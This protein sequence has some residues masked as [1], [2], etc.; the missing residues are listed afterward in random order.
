MDETDENKSDG[1]IKPDTNN[2]ENEP[3]KDDSPDLLDPSNTDKDE[4]NPEHSHPDTEGPSADQQL[5]QPV[6]ST[7]AAGI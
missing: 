1:A 3:K 2:S 7:T 4:G 5:V 6:D